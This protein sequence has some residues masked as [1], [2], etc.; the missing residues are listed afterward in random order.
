MHHLQDAQ[1]RLAD[2]LQAAYPDRLDRITAAGVIGALMGAA[3]LTR[4]V[5][6]KH[7][8]RP[9]QV[10]VATRQ[11]IDVAM[12]GVAAAA[13]QPSNPLPLSFLR[14]GPDGDLR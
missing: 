6:M 13:T 12:R 7:G 9:H 4:L 10:V 14:A 5:S 11:G 1:L 3:N 8:D 2:A